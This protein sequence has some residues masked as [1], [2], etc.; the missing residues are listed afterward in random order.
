M[1]LFT[2]PIDADMLKTFG[3]PVDTADAYYVFGKDE[4]VS[5]DEL[6]ILDGKT[7]SETVKEIDVNVSKELISQKNVVPAWSLWRLIRI[8]K[9]C[10]IGDYTKKEIMNT[11]L[12][13]ATSM[14]VTVAVMGITQLIVKNL[15]DFSKF[16]MGD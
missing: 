9:E 12:N 15:I 1:T 16:K 2:K 7:Y 8:I 5:D 3:V 14:M 13:E 10:G 4:T 6:F 11:I